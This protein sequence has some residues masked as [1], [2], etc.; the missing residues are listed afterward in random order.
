MQLR[1]SDVVDGALAL[2]D[3]EGLDQLTMRKLA[4]SLGVQA[5]GLYWHFENKQA[6]LDA[7][8]EKLLEGVGAPLDPGPWDQRLAVLAGRLRAALLSHRD[9]ARVVAGTYVSEPNTLLAGRTAVEVLG[10]A[11]IP[12]ERAGWVAF[13]VMYYVLG[14]TIEEQARQQLPGRDDWAVR[15]AA[16]SEHQD[17][18]FLR[19]LTSVVASDPTERFRYGVELFLD[20]LRHQLREAP[21][22]G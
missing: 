4:T 20:G 11:G 8:A 13:A 19:A 5:G 17:P 12:L 7:M 9:G 14:Y 1:R 2:I 10:T 21:P 3:A 18:Q 22:E 6:L 16:V 15:L